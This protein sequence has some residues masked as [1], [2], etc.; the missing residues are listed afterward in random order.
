MTILI[1]GGAYQG[2]IQYA[3][4]IFNL[5]EEKDIVYGDKCTQL[6]IKNA[7]AIAN[8]HEYIKR[9]DMQ[10]TNFE[11]LINLL[12]N[13]IIICDEIGCGVIPIEPSQNLLREFTGRLCCE[14]ASISHVVIRV[15]A[16]VPQFIKGSMEDIF[17]AS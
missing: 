16:G 12:K 9:L 5:D 15:F 2:K 13:K 1:I 4:K 8:L 17:N 11:T 7:K 10:N 3:K 14:I 6:Q